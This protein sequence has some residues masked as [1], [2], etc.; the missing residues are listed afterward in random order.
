M[1]TKVVVHAES[2]H[3]LSATRALFAENERRFSRFLPSSELSAINRRTGDSVDVSLEMAALLHHAMRLRERT[4][5]IVDPAVGRAVSVW[6]YDR[7][8]EEIADLPSRPQAPDTGAWGM[9][10]DRLH[11]DSGVMLDLGGLAKGWTCDLAVTTGCAA[12]VSAGGDVCSNHPETKIEVLDAVGNVA[13]VVALGEG[14]LA[15]S[16]VSRRTWLAGGER[17]HH[18][19]DP[20]TGS[21]ATSPMT[22]ATAVGASAIDAEAGAKA[23]LIMGAGG[24]QWADD[25][26]WLS[27][28]IAQWHDG[29]VYATGRLRS[30]L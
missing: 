22:S 29:T 12:I 16:S 17:A 5:G 19:I 4:G 8:F 2:S 7:T 1:G 10:G 14:A 11:L 6:G 21:P 30:K 9:E 23:V 18:V 20:R 28:A 3:G 15:T 24:L 26:P 25:Q 27:G 13:A